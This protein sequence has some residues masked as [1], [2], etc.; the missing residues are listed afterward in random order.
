MEPGFGKY[1]TPRG[2]LSTWS[3]LSGRAATL[4]CLPRITVPTVVVAFTGDN[5]V[6]PCDTDAIYEQSPAKDKTM[7]HVDGD[8]IGLPIPGKS[9][10]GRQGA[11]ELLVKWLR[12]RFAAR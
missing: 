5:A 6:F 1:M 7:Y 2:W 4:K 10:G 3:G 11:L 8:H 12:E 9:G